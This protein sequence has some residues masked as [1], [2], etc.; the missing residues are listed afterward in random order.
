MSLEKKPIERYFFFSLLALTTILVA[1]IFRPFL[2][3]VVAGASLAIVFQPLYLRLLRLV[4]HA[5]LA[6]GLSVALVV[7]VCALPVSIIA[8]I[9]FEQAEQVYAL[10]SETDTVATFLTTIASQMQSYLPIAIQ[11]DVHAEFAKILTTISQNI[12][13]FFSATLASLFTSVLVVVAWFYF[14]KDGRRWREEIFAL[15]PLSESDTTLI[16][17]KIVMAVNGV[18]KGYLFIALAQGIL[19]GLG[20]WLFG[21]PSP[22][23][24]GVVAA[25]V[26]MVPMLG[27]AF[28]SVPAVV[29]LVATGDTVSAIG[30][31]VWSLGLVGMIDNILSPFVL[32]SRI[33]L[34]PLLVLF[35]VLGGLAVFGPAG[36]LIGPILV[37]LL[38]SLIALY[39][40]EF[41]D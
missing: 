27:T 25:I 23:L 20:L 29:Y 31:L 24:W 3:V 38:Y 11:F 17:D 13:P 39:K 30:L 41:S 35:A 10:V 19:M 14:L 7:V 2:S 9:I 33:E 22:A 36:L 21:V 40:K 8:T 34:P 37:S 4:K 1:I 32:G 26:S 16:I 12:A 15:S 6:A 18:I 28:V 5:W